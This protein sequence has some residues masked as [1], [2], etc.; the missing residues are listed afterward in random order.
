[1]RQASHHTVT[2]LAT[3]AR[4]RKYSRTM[5]TRP[6]DSVSTFPDRAVMRLALQPARQRCACA[7]STPAASSARP[8]Q[9]RGPSSSRGF[10]PPSAA[11]APDR[12]R[13][14]RRRLAEKPASLR[15]PPDRLRWRR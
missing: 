7:H 12:R 14:P 1:M 9:P 10:V 5:R 8:A 6:D 4:W 15:A 2:I 13:A 3:K 11:A